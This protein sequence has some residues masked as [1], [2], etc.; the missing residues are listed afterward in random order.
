M[1]MNFNGRNKRLNQPKGETK[2][3]EKK[4]DFTTLTR[5]ENRRQ[6]PPSKKKRSE[7]DYVDDQSDE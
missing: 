1:T 4:N 6:S 3:P 5:T 7:D 2:N